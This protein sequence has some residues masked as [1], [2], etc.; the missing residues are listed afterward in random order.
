M[1]TPSAAAATMAA[2][3]V[4]VYL[5]FA[6][7]TGM[8][9]RH[10]RR[11]GLSAPCGCVGSS[12]PLSFAVTLRALGA[13]SLVVV[14]LVLGRRLHFLGAGV[15][16]AALLFVLHWIPDVLGRHIRLLPR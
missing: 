2:P 15:A 9:L 6:I 16:S 7:Y 12:T 5:V 1:V 10:L 3:V 4:G 8:A 14:G 13:A 11:T